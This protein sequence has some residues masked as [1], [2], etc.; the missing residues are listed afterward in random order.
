[1]LGGGILFLITGNLIFCF[2]GLRFLSKK[3][4][5]VYFKSEERIF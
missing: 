1:M 3:E 2:K 5:D 4:V